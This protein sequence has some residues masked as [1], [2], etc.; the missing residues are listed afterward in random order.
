VKLFRKKY[1]N[2]ADEQ[3][4]HLLTQGSEVAFDE[5][6]KRYAHKMHSYFHKLL[7]QDNELAA[8]FCQ[9]LFLK[10]FEKANSY[11]NSYKFSTW[12]YTI[13]SN[14]VKNEYRRQQNPTPT[15]F[16]QQSQTTH[17]DPQGPKNIDQEIFQKKLQTALN[18]L[19][20]KHRLCFILRYQ[21]EKTIKEISEILA[22]PIGT[23]KSRIHYTMKKIA[24]DLKLLNPYTNR[25][26]RYNQ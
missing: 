5:L 23:I 14:M 9:N 16:I 22:C 12:L 25:N 7:Y 6:Y 20:D 2:Y 13:A 8:D 10:V 21:E 15:L 3:L 1:E 17:I 19:E 4:M 24:E 26:E 11:N 18:K